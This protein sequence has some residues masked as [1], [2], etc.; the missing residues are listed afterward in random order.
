MLKP[1]RI[2]FDVRL[3]FVDLRRGGLGISSRLLTLKE[4]TS[5]PTSNDPD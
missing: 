5:C 1:V 4:D 3:V 2:E